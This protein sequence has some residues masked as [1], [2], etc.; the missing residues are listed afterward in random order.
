MDAGTRGRLTRNMEY[1]QSLADYYNEQVKPATDEKPATRTRAQDAQTHGDHPAPAPAKKESPQ[2]TQYKHLA[3]V[4]GDA[5]KQLKELL[6]A[7]VM[8]APP[9]LAPIQRNASVTRL[10]PVPFR[11]H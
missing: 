2:E 10:G 11:V 5:A 7:D 8:V 6:D 9:P 4:H 1:H 3:E